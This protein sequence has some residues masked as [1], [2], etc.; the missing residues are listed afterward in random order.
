MSFNVRLFDLYNWT[1]NF[2]TRKQ[3]FDFLSGESPDVLCLQEYYTSESTDQHFD[4]NDTLNKILNTKYS[5]IEYSLTLRRKDHWGIA[6]FSK[7][8][9]INKGAVN[10]QKDGGNIFIFSDIVIGSDTVRVFNTHLESIRFNTKDYQ[11]IENFAKGNEQDEIGISLSILKRLK[12]AFINRS[13]QVALLNKHVLASP[14][15]VILCGDLND[16]PTSYAYSILSK[17]LKD[18]FRESGSGSGKTYAGKFPSFR[19]DYILHDEKLQ[20]SGYKTYYNKLSDHYPLSCWI[21]KE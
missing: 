4:N 16:T 10:F 1:H 8:P 11:F 5:Q 13:M 14:Y 15:P 18:A 12:R 9:I 19:I 2:E 21:Y 7:F 20:S 3:I 17:K 6:T